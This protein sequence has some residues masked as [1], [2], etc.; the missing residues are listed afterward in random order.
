MNTRDDPI[1]FERFCNKNQYGHCSIL[2]NNDFGGKPCPFKKERDIEKK[3]D[4]DQ[5]DF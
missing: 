1:C 3:E 2:T 5:D 4:E